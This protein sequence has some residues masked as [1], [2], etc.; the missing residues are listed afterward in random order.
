[1]HQ[2]GDSQVLSQQFDAQISA[3]VL[4]EGSFALGTPA[5]KSHFRGRLEVPRLTSLPEQDFS[6]HSTKSGSYIVNHPKD[7]W[8]GIRINFKDGLF[9]AGNLQVASTDNTVE[10]GVLV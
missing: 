3:L 10:A 5:H 9:E 7:H 1:M 4:E 6:F 2:F 8:P